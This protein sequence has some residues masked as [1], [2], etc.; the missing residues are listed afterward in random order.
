MSKEN[1]QG[2][3][4]IMGSI[5]TDLVARS[6]HLP[7]PGETISGHEFAQ[8]SGGKGANQAVAAARIGGRV[9][10]AGCVG[11]DAN[12][13][14][15]LADLEAEGIDC[16]AIRIPLFAWGEFC[17]AGRSSPTLCRLSSQPAKYADRSID[18]GHVC[19]RSEANQEIFG[20]RVAQASA[21]G[22][23]LRYLLCQTP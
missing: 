21:C 5:N 16:I 7:R 4:L 9:T 23:C 11:G 20:F 6:P 3:V 18:A 1:K 8:I 13:T 17:L 15:R 14:L 22:F 12:G 19:Q 2:S 10:M